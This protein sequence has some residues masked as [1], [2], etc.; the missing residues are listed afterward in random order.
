MI[1]GELLAELK[2]LV[3]QSILKNRNSVTARLRAIELSGGDRQLP[4]T[5]VELLNLESILPLK[6][7]SVCFPAIV[8]KMTS[9][10]DRQYGK[11][12]SV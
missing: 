1:S 8:E 12:T 10:T 11:L 7:V 6:M 3:N 9:H 2:S 4:T 5:A